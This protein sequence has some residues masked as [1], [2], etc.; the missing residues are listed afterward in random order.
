MKFLAVSTNVADPRPY[1]EAETDRMGDLMAEGV[2]EI[3]Y[4]KADWSGA[5]VIV[6]A[7]DEATAQDRLGTLPL[8]QNHVTTFELTSLF[9]PPAA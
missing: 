7:A 1:I 2:V 4:P 9:V 8:V 6:E 3:V 5:V